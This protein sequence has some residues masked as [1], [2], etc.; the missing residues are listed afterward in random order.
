MTSDAE[1]GE[2][3]LLFVDIDG[4]ISLHG[5]GAAGVESRLA[6]V[7]G[8]LVC[9]SL[10]AARELRALAGRFEMVW[11]SGWEERADEHL[12]YLLDLPRGLPHLSFARDVG[13][14]HAHW[15]LDAIEAFA[16]DRALAWIDD[17]LDETCE[18]WAARRGAPALLVRTDPARG[19]T[20]REREVLA[21]W[22]VRRR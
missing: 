17:S 13:R 1:G 20:A 21:R 7:D 15:K 9:L 5:A 3:P 18:R 14:S 16:G 10:T 11:A 4:V 22:A 12:P 8:A 6:N 2:P 19:F